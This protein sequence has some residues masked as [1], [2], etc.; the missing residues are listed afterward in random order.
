M[1]TG[2]HCKLIGLVWHLIVLEKFK[3]DEIQ[4]PQEILKVIHKLGA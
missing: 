2:R 1:R 4:R 3:T